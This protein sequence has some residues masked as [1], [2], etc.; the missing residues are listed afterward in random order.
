MKNMNKIL[1]LI[2]L[3]Y[4]TNLIAQRNKNIPPPPPSKN[5]SNKNN[6]YKEIALEKRLNNFPFK[7]ATK[8]EI[9]SFNLESDRIEDLPKPI[10]KD[11]IIETKIE[12]AN[13]DFIS[14]EKLIAQKEFER[15]N[16]RKTLTLNSINILSDILYNTCSKYNNYTIIKKGC[17]NPRNGILFYNEFGEIYEYLEIC[18][19]CNETI[20]KSK[21]D[22]ETEN[23]CTYLYSE[24]NKFFI[25]NGI[26]TSKRIKE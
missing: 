4:S 11:S 21:K 1:I 16:Q 5:H 13:I 25:K 17:Y 15:I 22:D 24:L 9:I 7:D 12:I 26:E 10:L 2:F 23:Y 19:E 3:L 20:S 18:F 8:I 6:Y 14:L